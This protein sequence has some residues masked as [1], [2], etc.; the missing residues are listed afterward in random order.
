MERLSVNQIIRADF[1]VNKS[2]P[3]LKPFNGS[4]VVADPSLLTPDNSHD[5][6]WHLFCHTTFGIH[7]FASDDGI[8]FNR[9][10][11]VVNRAMRPNINYID[12]KYYLYTVD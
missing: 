7:H 5:G 8:D 6:K 10:N 12:G 11:K 1:K 2:S 4:F 3:V 9:V